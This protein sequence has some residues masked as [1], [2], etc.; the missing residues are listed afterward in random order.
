MGWFFS[1]LHVKKTDGLTV[2]IV[3]NSISDIMKNGGAVPAE[4]ENEADIVMLLYSSESPWLSVCLDGL[5]FYDDKSS[6][7]IIKPLSALLKTDILSVA[8]FD[9]D[10]LFLHMINEAE[11]TDAWA[12]VGHNPEGKFPRRT[13]FSDWKNKVNDL[14]KFKKCIRQKYDFAEEVLESLEDVLNLSYKQSTICTES[15]EDF[16]DN[17]NLVKMCFSLP[18]VQKESTNLKIKTFGLTACKTGEFNYVSAINQGGSSRGLAIAFTGDYVEND[19][20]TFTDVTLEYDFTS[21]SRKCIPVQLEKQQLPDGKWAYC[22]K[23]TTVLIP[24]KVKDGLSPKRQMDL[25]YKRQLGIRFTPQG[26][27]R[28]VLDICLHFIPLSNQLGQCCW[29]VWHPFGSKDEYIKRFNHLWSKLPADINLN[30]GDFD[31]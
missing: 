17:H 5:E 28:K 6:E 23:N 8:C 10:Y 26:N 3:K 25:Q 12:N 14:E 27:P 31:V 21:T 29:C 4:N 30:P 19:E 22:W 7:N 13:K 18:D 2:D 1:N 11:K 16:E 15:V 24:E 20:I 9:S